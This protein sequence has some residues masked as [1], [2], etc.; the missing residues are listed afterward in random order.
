MLSVGLF[1]KDIDRPIYT[2]VRELNDTEFDGR[3]YSQLFI[4]QPQN[5]KKG[6]I[7]GIELSVQQ[8]F[9]SLPSPFDGFGFAIGYTYSDSEAEVF[10][11]P[12]KTP[13][14]LQ[15][16][17]VGNASIF[18]EKAG[19]EA[20]LAYAY[21]SPYLEEL[22]DGPA[23]DLYIDKHGQLDFKASYQFTNNTTAFIEM[24]NI[25]DE[26]VRFYSGTPRRLAE[27]ERYSWNAVMGVQLKF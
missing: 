12:K 14:F 4:E 8:Q 3:F 2:L 5:A 25:T 15:S 17:H 10:N 16:K 9:R 21:R 7:L 26:P 23:Q 1:Y 18:Y 22:G 24:K 20:R 11:R 13:F 6:E 19:F 27:N